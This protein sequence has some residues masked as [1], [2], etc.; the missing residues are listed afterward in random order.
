MTPHGEEQ[1]EI[2]IRMAQKESLEDQQSEDDESLEDEK[3]EDDEKMT[4]DG[5]YDGLMYRF[6]LKRGLEKM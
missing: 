6:L 3:S 1:T 5:G 2:L 4:P